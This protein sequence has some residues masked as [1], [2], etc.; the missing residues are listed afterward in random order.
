MGRGTY[1]VGL[2]EGITNPYPQIKQYV[3]SR[4]LKTNPDP[5]VELVSTD[6]VAFVRELKQ[7]PGKNLVEATAQTPEGLG[8]SDHFLYIGKKRGSH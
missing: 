2:K 5:N 1:E 4:T 3:V 6:P 7:Q 8:M